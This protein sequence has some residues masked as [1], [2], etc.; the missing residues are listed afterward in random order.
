MPRPV[1][2]ESC[3]TSI[4]Y[5]AI[6]PP[7]QKKK[8]VVGATEGRPVKLKKQI[9]VTLKI[10]DLECKAIFLITPKLSKSCVLGMDVLKPLGG[11]INFKGDTLTIQQEKRTT[12]IRMHEEEVSAT[13]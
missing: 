11:I 5:F 9:F 12:T 13:N 4:K 8:K 1:L 7:H 6:F 2:G 3:T 10:A